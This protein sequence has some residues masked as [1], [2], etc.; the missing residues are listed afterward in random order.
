M[1]DTTSRTEGN[2]APNESVDSSLPTPSSSPLLRKMATWGSWGAWGTG[3]GADGYAQTMGR[4]FELTLTLVVFGGL[5][6]LVDRVVG[7]S[8]LFTLGFGLLAFVG[9]AL[10]L[11]IAYDLEMR[12]HDEGAIWSRRPSGDEDP[13]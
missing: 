8:P 12:Q 6:W 2:E 1:T 7:T 3:D 10:K 11:W 9:V 5:G 4:G 13:S